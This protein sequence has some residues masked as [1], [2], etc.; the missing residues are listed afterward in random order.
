MPRRINW[1]T[2]HLTEHHPDALKMDLSEGIHVGNYPAWLAYHEHIARP[3]CNMDKSQ[4]VRPTDPDNFQPVYGGP[5]LLEFL[6]EEMDRLME[7]LMTKTDAEDGGDR[8]RAEELGFI[9]AVVQNVYAPSV[10]AVRAEALRRFKEG[11]N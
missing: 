11:A 7:G 1:L 8:F 4:V 3:E 6:W 10:P 9:I 2:Q 5:T